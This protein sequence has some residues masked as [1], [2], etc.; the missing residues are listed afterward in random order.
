LRTSS[1]VIGAGQ[2][3]SMVAG[4]NGYDTAIDRGVRCAVQITLLYDGRQD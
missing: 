3:Q 4:R 2:P 1:D